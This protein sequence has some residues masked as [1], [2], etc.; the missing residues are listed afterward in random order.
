VGPLQKGHHDRISHF[1]QS[2][3]NKL[4]N[5]TWKLQIEKQRQVAS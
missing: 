2:T 4:R 5:E 3:R 1:S